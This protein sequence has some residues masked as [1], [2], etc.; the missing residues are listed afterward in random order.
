[1]FNST[2]NQYIQKYYKILTLKLQ[3][4]QNINYR[5]FRLNT[6][7]NRVRELQY[8]DHLLT[9]K[10]FIAQRNIFVSLLAFQIHN[11]NIETCFAQ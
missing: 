3:P 11:N 5:K 9:V 7:I 10:F 6:Y 4:Y 8:L 2:S 1:M